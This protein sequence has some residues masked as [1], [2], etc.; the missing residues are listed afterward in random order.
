MKGYLAYWSSTI[1]RYLRQVLA[2]APLLGASGVPAK[3][4]VG[5][6]KVNENG[7]TLRRRSSGLIEGKLVLVRLEGAR[8]FQILLRFPTV[9]LNFAGA[10]RLAH[11]AYKGQYSLILTL[12]ALATA[13]HLRVDDTI[14]TLTEL[15][16]LRY[17]RTATVVP[18]TARGGDLDADLEEDGAI[19]NAEEQEGDDDEE[20]MGEWKDVEV[21]ISRE[22]VERLMKVW[23]VRD[24]TMLDPQYVLL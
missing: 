21:V 24:N 1:L 3:G 11:P 17:R 7:R 16:L 6:G 13:C 20:E 22:E 18:P 19:D 4:A 12:G 10:L 9:K 23:G 8:E 14:M 5:K 2:D 15:G